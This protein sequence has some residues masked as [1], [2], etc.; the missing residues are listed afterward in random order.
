MVWDLRKAD[1][2]QVAVYGVLS[3]EKYYGLI[4]TELYLP[5]S[6]TSDKKRCKAAGVSKE[7]WV[8]QSKIDL[9]LDIVKRQINLGIPFGFVGA[10]GLYE[11][12]N[13]FC[14]TLDY[15]EVLYV[16]DVHV[17]Q[18]VHEEPPNI[19]VLE[20]QGARGSNSTRYKSDSEAVEIK[21]LCP[22]KNSMKWQ[23]IRLRKTGKGDLVCK[24]YL[25]TVYT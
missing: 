21:A 7:W 23:R 24:G 8:H 10:D 14:Q 25:Q 12:S 19:Y 6:W 1:N 18:Y 5:E 9:A 16:L 3:A 22:G 4:D 13:H 11:N 15:L 2:C 17:D 20:K